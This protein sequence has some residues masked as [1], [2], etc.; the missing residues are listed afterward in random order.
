[1]RK[2][3]LATVT[4]AVL[5]AMHPVNADVTF[6]D[7]TFNGLDYTLT[8]EG[9]TAGASLLLTFQ[10]GGVPLG[11]GLVVQGTFSIAAANNLLALGFLNTGF[12]YDPLTQG[13]ITAISASVLKDLATNFQTT[14][15]GNTFRP[16][17]QQ[18]GVDYLAAIPGPTLTAPAGGGSTGFNTLANNDLTA[19]DFVA[20]DFTSDVAPPTTGAH[21]NFAGDPM[22][23]GLAQVFGFNVQ[24]VPTATYADLVIDVEN[25]PEP[26][27]LALLGV[28]LAGL[29]FI[30][31]R[32]A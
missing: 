31:R 28:G 30:R 7:T 24:G 3:L 16:L 27:S 18:D 5:A 29:G 1:M 12:T 22:T 14:G 25:V 9:A 8:P 32:M 13:P 21:P 19:T 23:F 15:S 4:L 10:A 6:T 26:A 2:L 11:T 17:I 20:Y